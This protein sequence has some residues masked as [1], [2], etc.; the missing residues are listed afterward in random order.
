M[1]HISCSKGSDSG[2][3]SSLIVGK[4]NLQSSREKITAPP[5]SGEPSSDE[6]FS[7]SGTVEFKSNGTYEYCSDGSCFTE[8][9]KV[10]GS[11]LVTSPEANFSDPDNAT[12][13]T[14]TSSKLVL[15]NKETYNSNGYNIVEE[16]W[17]TLTR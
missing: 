5:A 10:S 11:T 13:Q 4:W 6:T 2:S 17:T 9:Y 3:N 8:Y 16:V 7:I 14:L 15:Y 1:T 12:I